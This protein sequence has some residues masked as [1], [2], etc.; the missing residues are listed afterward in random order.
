MSTSHTLEHMQ[1]M[2]EINWTKNKGGCQLRRKV[3]TH[4]T[5]EGFASSGMRANYPSKLVMSPPEGAK[6][7]WQD[8]SN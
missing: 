5:K 8:L 3:V 4:N 7:T 1:K 6:S 2:F